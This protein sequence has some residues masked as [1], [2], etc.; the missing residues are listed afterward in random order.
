M[1]KIIILF[2]LLFSISIANDFDTLIKRID[3]LESSVDSLIHVIDKN[4]PDYKGT[5]CLIIDD[6]GYA[7]DQETMS[8]FN[9]GDYITISIIPGKDYTQYLSNLS[10]SLNIEAI[11][12]MPME[13]HDYSKT[14]E[15]KYFLSEGMNQFEVDLIVSSAFP[16]P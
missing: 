16:L 14:T 5:I 6:F 8:F 10:D 1:N 9:L 7:N 4:K 13:P 11:V 12:H 2:S 3:K 15:E